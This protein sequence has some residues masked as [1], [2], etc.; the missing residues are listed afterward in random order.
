MP[1]ACAVFLPVACGG[2]FASARTDVAFVVALL[3]DCV[4]IWL[5]TECLNTELQME[6][7]DNGKSGNWVKSS[8]GLKRWV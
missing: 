6:G 3:R 1:L 5:A 4:L 7:H 8:L 2:V